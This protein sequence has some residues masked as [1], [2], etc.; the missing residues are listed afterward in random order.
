MGKSFFITINELTKTSGYVPLLV[1]SLTSPP[2]NHKEAKGGKALQLSPLDSVHGSLAEMQP[3]W[4]RSDFPNEFSLK[5]ENHFNLHL[6]NY[7][8]SMAGFVTWFE[9]CRS[10]IPAPITLFKKKTKNIF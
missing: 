10:V 3:L 2:S 9:F 4:F 5:R 8:T 7:V 6:V 1:P